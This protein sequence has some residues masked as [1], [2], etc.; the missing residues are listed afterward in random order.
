VSGERLFKNGRTRFPTFSDRS[1]SCWRSRALVPGGIAATSLKRLADL[2]DLPTIS[3]SG[4]PGAH[5]RRDRQVGARDQGSPHPAGL[6]I[7]TQRADTA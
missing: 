5:Q 7:P 2:P 6:T 3:E 1:R 4:L